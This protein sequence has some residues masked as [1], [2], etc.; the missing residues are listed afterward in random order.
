MK[1]I[2]KFEKLGTWKKAA[3]K[4]VPEVGVTVMVNHGF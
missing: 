4:V 1:A 2:G 3:T